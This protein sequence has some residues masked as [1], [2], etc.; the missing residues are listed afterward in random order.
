MTLP[1]DAHIG[2]VSLTVRDLDRSLLFYRGVLG[3]EEVRRD[4]RISSLAAPGG[5]VIIETIF[6]LPGLGLLAQ[7]SAVQQDVPMLLGIV[8]VTA[9]FIMFINVLVDASYGFFNPKLRV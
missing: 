7:Q 3:F 5:T 1:A 8:A 2:Q 4:G 6:V 9:A